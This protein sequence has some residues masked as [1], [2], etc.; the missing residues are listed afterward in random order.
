MIREL[1]IIERNKLINSDG[2]RVS[3]NDLGTYNYR[4]E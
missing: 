3:I 4:K 1:T 2:Y